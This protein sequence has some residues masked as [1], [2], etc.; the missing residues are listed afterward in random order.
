M[1]AEAA[2]R[3]AIQAAGTLDDG[4]E[5]RVNMLVP[6]IAAMLRPPKP[7]QRSSTPMLVAEQVAAA[8][9]IFGV[10][11]GKHFDE[12]SQRIVVQLKA[13]NSDRPEEMRTHRVDET[14]GQAMSLR[15]MQIHEGDRCA[16]FKYVEGVDRQ[17]KVRYLVAIEKQPTKNSA[18]A[19]P[20]QRPRRTGAERPAVASPVTAAAPAPNQSKSA[21]IRGLLDDLKPEARLKA[22]AML[23]QR[24]WETADEIPDDD[25]ETAMYIARHQREDFY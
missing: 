14:A 9:V 4:W 20:P 19:T 3:L 22:I 2:V 21:V 23:K 11:L 13:D 6:A 12:Q 24:G 18:V 16:F 1:S 25:F 17:T 5:T 7:G 8:D 15:L 10:Y